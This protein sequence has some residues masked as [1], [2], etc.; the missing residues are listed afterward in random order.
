MSFFTSARQKLFSRKALAKSLLVSGIAFLLFLSFTLVSYHWVKS[1]TKK[2]HFSTLAEVP[3]NDIALLLGTAEKTRRGYI[4]PYFSTR[5]KAAAELYHTGKVKHILVSG[6]N[7][8]R[9]YNEPI[10]M[11]KH[12][13]KL[14]VPKSA[15]TLDYAGF[16]TFDSM[17]RAKE[18]FGQSKFTVVSQQFHNERALFICNALGIEAIAY[19]A[20]AVNTSKS[21]MY[22][23]ELFARSKA[24]LDVYILQTKPKFLGKRETILVD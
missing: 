7:K 17:V 11:Q 14:G 18:V 23:R 13:I 8:T 19:N 5:M 2:Q 15:I 10:A 3:T 9:N 6:D 16:R 12:L 1:S 24:V 20:S 22:V 21:M 4:N